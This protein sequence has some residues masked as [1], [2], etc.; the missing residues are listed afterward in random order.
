MPTPRGISPGA[1]A[2]AVTTFRLAS[3]DS[4]NLLEPAENRIRQPEKPSPPQ[5]KTEPSLC[6]GQDPDSTPPLATGT[7]D[8][9]PGVQSKR[10]PRKIQGN[11]KPKEGAALRRA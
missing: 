6:E 3:K 11:R 2:A 4:G 8:T 1:L 10:I 7:N 9:D 5:P